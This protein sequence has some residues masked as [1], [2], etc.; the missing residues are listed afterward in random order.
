[1]VNQPPPNPRIAIITGAAQGIGEAIALRLADDGIDVVLNDLSTKSDALDGV[2][3]AVQAKGRRAIAVLGDAMIEADVIALV[4]KAVEEFGGLDIMVANAGIG[5]L[6]SLVDM[7]VDVWDHIMCVNVR[8][9]MLAYKHAARQMI[10]QGRGGRIVGAASMAG[11]KGFATLP[12][13]CASKFA[14][15]GLTQSAALELAEHKITVNSY[16]PGVITTA[17]TQHPDDEKNGGPSSTFILRAGWPPNTPTA[18]PS[19]VADLVAYIVKPEAHFVTGQ[20]L[21][22]DGGVVMD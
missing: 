2:V 15:R 4:D 13:Y 12:V 10:K 3:K 8:S 6:L 18:P 19:A 20:C 1:M 17:L 5:K 16:A 9:V 11:K 21:S 22:V 14:V 7:T